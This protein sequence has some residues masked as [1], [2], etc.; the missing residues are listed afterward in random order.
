MGNCSI[1]RNCVNAV[2]L[3]TERLAAV[4]MSMLHFVLVGFVYKTQERTKKKSKHII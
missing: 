3:A 2:L 4:F 1:C